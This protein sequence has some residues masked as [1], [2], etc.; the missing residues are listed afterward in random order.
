[1]ILGSLL[2]NRESYSC[3]VRNVSAGVGEGGSRFR[4]DKVVELQVRKRDRRAK[5]LEEKGCR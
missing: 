5:V 2:T 1:M 3:E 4:P